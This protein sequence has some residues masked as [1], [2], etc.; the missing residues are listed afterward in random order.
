ML[1][2]YPAREEPIEGVNSEMLASKIT[3]PHTSIVSKAELV[4]ELRKRIAEAHEPMV[5]L[6]VGAGDIDRLVPQIADMIQTN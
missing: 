3:N 1:P 2:I 6:T 5:V 4:G